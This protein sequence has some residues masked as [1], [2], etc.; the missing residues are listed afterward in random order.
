M[1]RLHLFLRIAVVFLPLGYLFAKDTRAAFDLGSGTFKVFVAEVSNDSLE[2]KFSRSIPVG[3]GL[4]LAASSDK[5]FP[6][7]SYQTA[8]K[9]LQQLR[10]DALASGATQFT[11]IATAA[12]REAENGAQLL[13]F[14]ESE[15]NIALRII[16]QEEEAVLGFETVMALFPKYSHENTVVIDMGAASFQLT[17]CDAIGYNIHL[18]NLGISHVVKSFFEEIRKVP[19]SRGMT[20]DPIT[21]E[22]AQKLVEHIKTKVRFPSW[23]KE[24]ASQAAIE[25]IYCDEPIAELQSEA[26]RVSQAKIAEVLFRKDDQQDSKKHSIFILNYS[27]LYSIISELDIDGFLL[28]EI[29]SGCG[30]AVIRQGQFWASES[31]GLPVH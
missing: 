15:A 30:A 22:E 11:G 12:F 29:D 24:K 7:K 17:A 9:A 1:A 8:L 20:F 31:M 10:E 14:L 28:K 27:L 4:D 6:A 23:L 16:S 5:K 13:Q 2:W 25:F 3:L 21:V 26:G 18:G 19:Y